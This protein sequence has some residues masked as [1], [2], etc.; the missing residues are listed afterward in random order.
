MTT[1]KRKAEEQLTRSSVAV[2]EP[3]Q[4]PRVMVDLSVHLATAWD[5]WTG[6]YR[7]LFHTDPTCST[8]TYETAEVVT[9]D[10]LQSTEPRAGGET[11]LKRQRTRRSKQPGTRSKSA[12]DIQRKGGRGTL[13]ITGIQDQT[14]LRRRLDDF[15]SPPELD[16]FSKR[17]GSSRLPIVTQT[18]Q[19]SEEDGGDG[20]NH[21][22][23]GFIPRRHS[24][25]SESI[26]A[27]ASSESILGQMPNLHNS[28]FRTSTVLRPLTP[29]SL[30]RQKFPPLQP[31][32]NDDITVRIE[33]ILDSLENLPTSVRGS[34][35]R[36]EKAQ[37]N[38]RQ[39]R[40]AAVRRAKELRLSRRSP[41]K[42]LVQ[43]L[44]P[45][46][47]RRVYDAEDSNNQYQVMTKS[48]EGTELRLK[49]FRTLLGRHA[50]L[51]DEIINSYIEWIV[52]AAN[53]DAAVKGEFLGEPPSTVPKFIAHNSFFYEN[54]KKKGPQST[55]RLMKRKKAPGEKLL[56]VDSVFVPICQGS[57]W[58]MGV[59][60]PVAKTIEYF[61]SM[62]GRPQTFISQMRAWLQHQLGEL[63]NP[64][65]WTEPRTACARQSNG[66]DCG[67]FV[68]T[69]AFCIAMGLDTSCYEERDM[70]LQRRSI[71][72]V[73]L[74]QGFIGDFAWNRWGLLS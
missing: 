68:C 40:E 63:Y 46:W 56:E 18:P 61:D 1:L 11:T 6:L 3:V 16:F 8:M 34:A 69:N 43:P 41:L 26:S 73:L 31:R 58:T 30:P 9:E 53:D 13:D 20:G 70:V 54:L 33:D 50:W 65:E 48:M 49:D 45:K 74:N 10:H 71:A 22:S 29:D 19:P 62:G 28:A 51:N 2:I 60:R 36:D 57:H 14:E 27:S 47:D 21:G 67:V 24:D 44:N 23:P 35:I 72:A 37:E 66:Y 38:K 25:P 5:W 39:A 52:K 17:S 59:V 7:S 42:P 12:V 55:D 4:A 64:E 32:K 15:W